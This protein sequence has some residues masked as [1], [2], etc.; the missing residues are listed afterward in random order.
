MPDQIKNLDFTLPNSQATE[1]LMYW[2]RFAPYGTN[3]VQVLHR[4]L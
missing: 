1:D 3:A 2:N 4:Q